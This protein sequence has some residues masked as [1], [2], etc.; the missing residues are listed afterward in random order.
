MPSSVSSRIPGARVQEICDLEE[1]CVAVAPSGDR[2]GQ[3][4]QDPAGCPLAPDGRI[5]R[6]LH[7]GPRSPGETLSEREGYAASPDSASTTLSG[8]GRRRPSPHARASQISPSHV[9]I[10][11]FPMRSFGNERLNYAAPRPYGFSIGPSL[12]MGRSTGGKWQF[13]RLECRMPE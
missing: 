11:S 5:A 8:R 3:R 4:P 2:D 9:T 6:R 7:E 10:G 13:S 1:R 12:W